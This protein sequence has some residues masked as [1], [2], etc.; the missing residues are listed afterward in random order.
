MAWLMGITLLRAADHRTMPWKNGGGE[1][2]EIAVSPPHAGLADFDWRI[3]MAKV[4]SDGSFSIFPEIDRTFSK[5]MASRFQS[6][7]KVRFISTLSQ[8]PCHFLRMWLSTPSWWAAPLP[9]STS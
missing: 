5:A 8:N 4:A 9:I 6:M 1:T 7:C 3:S 2:T